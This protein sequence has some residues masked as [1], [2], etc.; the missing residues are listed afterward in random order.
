MYGGV[1]NLGEGEMCTT[2]VD[3]DPHS[4]VPVLLVGVRDEF[5]DRPWRAPGRHWSGHPTLVGGQDLQA[6]G[7]WLAVDL[8]APRVACVLNGHT[9]TPPDEARR[10][11]RGRLPLLLAGG[12][13]LG[14][15]FD[16]SRYE[17]FHLVCAMP[18]SVRLW[19]WNGH[20]L[21]ERAL[22]SGVHIIVN[23]GLEGADDDDERPGAAQMRARI[24][25]FRPL[26]EK[27]RRPEP[28]EADG[29]AETAWG[30]WLPLVGG[31]GLDPADSRALVLRG[32]IDA[33][34][35][36]T[37]S[38]SLVALTRTAARYDFCA[39]PHDAHPTWSRVTESG[40]GARSPRTAG[41][42]SPAG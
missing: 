27:A 20:T 34:A 41:R 10:L 19:S 22:S 40:L 39:D 2:I 14:D 30:A 35:W 26:L 38:V 9:D 24:D 15:G 37:S 25:H 32:T 4:P 3:I 33:R 5:S 29:P 12:A 1:R 42:R 16:P 23:T 21:T 7:T 11:T 18:E 17:P 8:G 28:G 31:G 36:G 6:L 13:D